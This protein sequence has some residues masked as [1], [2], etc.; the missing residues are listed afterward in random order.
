[1]NWYKRYI[2]AVRKIYVP[3]DDYDKLMELIEKIARGERNWTAEE[4]ELQQNY[5]EAVEV[6]LRKK[7]KAVNE[8]V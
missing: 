7:T 1:M 5:S 6:L 4:L 3:P 2:L 8:L